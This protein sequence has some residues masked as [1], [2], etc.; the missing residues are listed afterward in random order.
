MSRLIRFVVVVLL[1]AS[2]PLAAQRATS[3][4]PAPGPAQVRPLLLGSS[5]PDAPLRRIDGR[6]TSLKEV[7]G[8][9]PAILVFYRGSWCPYC[10]LQL[11]GL[12]LIERE[13]Q[14]LGYQLIAITPDRPEEMQKT[15]D[16][17]ALTYTLVSDVEAKAMTAFGIAYRAD[18]EL[19]GMLAK[20][21]VDLDKASGAAHHELPVPSVFIIDAE[22]VIQFEY[23]HPDYRVRAPAEVI[24]AAARAIAQQ[25]HKLK[26]VH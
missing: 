6:P 18:A 22:G 26:P 7:T 9:K 21:G 10:N 5:V 23:V 14:D 3:A 12:R 24:L 15:L 25:K 16:K 20:G 8:G 19:T 1:L 4:E 17:N 11:S 13:V 2:T